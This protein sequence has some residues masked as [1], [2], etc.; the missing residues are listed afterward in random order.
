MTDNALRAR[1]QPA[2]PA[3]DPI[4]EVMRHALRW[5][6]LMQKQPQESELAASV[7]ERMTAVMQKAEN[8]KGDTGR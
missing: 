4:A 1:T 5:C 3:V 6:A 8:T 2:L 7:R